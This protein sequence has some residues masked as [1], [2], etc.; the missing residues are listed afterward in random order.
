M[1]PPKDIARSY[2]KRGLTADVGFRSEPKFCGDGSAYFDNDN[3]TATLST[4]PGSSFS[5]GLWMNVS[6]FVPSNQAVLIEI[7]AAGSAG[8]QVTI[9]LTSTGQVQIFNGSGFIGTTAANTVSL[10]TWHFI[11]VAVDGSSGGLKIYVDGV[12]VTGTHTATFN[13]TDKGMTV[14]A[15][16]PSSSF[17]TEGN[18]AN[19]FYCTEIL[20]QDQVRQIMRFSSSSQFATITGMESFYPLSADFND[21][22][23]SANLTNSGATLQVT[24]KPQLPRGLDLV[25]GAAQARCFTGRAVEFDGSAD[26]LATETSAALGNTFTITAWIKRNNSAT[27]DYIVNVGNPH[28]AG[29]AI[30]ISIT[31]ANPGYLYFF[32]NSTS[33]NTTNKVEYNTWYHVAL[34]VSSGA[35][36]VKLYANGVDGTPSNSVDVNITDTTFEIGRYL[37]N[38]HFHN[39]WISDVRVY[40]QTLTAA[41]VKELYQHPEQLLPNGSSASNLIHRWALSDYND[42]GGTG[43]RHFQDSAGSNPMEDKASAQM[44]FAQPVPCPQLGLQQSASRI[45]WDDNTAEKLS[46]T[47]PAFDSDFTIAF[48]WFRNN[49]ADADV[50]F[51]VNTPGLYQLYYD[52]TQIVY[53][54][55]TAG[56]VYTGVSCAV[57]E[58]SHVAITSAGIFKNGVKHTPAF[59]LDWLGTEYRIF[60]RHSAAL[61][62]DGICSNMGFWSDDLSTAAI[63]EL[64]NQ[65]P[66]YDPRNDTGNYASSSTLTNLWFMDDLATIKD[67]KGSNDLTVIGDPILASFPENAS[68]S[69]LVGDFSMKRKGVSVLNCFGDPGDERVRTEIPSGAGLQPSLT[70]GH[71]VSCWYRNQKQNTTSANNG[72]MVLGGDD[73]GNNRFILEAFNGNTLRGIYGA[74]TATGTATISDNEWHHYAMVLDVTTASPT[75]RLYLDGV[76]AGTKSGSLSTTFPEGKVVIGGLNTTTSRGQFDYGLKGPIACARIYAFQL[77]ENEIKQIYH[78]DERLIKG[79]N[80]E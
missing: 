6:D 41:Q 12:D 21:A 59:T 74:Q 5:Y 58:W 75:V 13:V 44:E 4:T 30:S 56:V 15:Y 54:S 43:G 64:Y 7:G 71:T 40:N 67:R 25:R 29:N 14:G 35:G 69:T 68:G 45:Y 3:A 37:G 73:S 79:L 52:L 55:S 31:N 34:T 48:W 46:A 47:I 51:E 19:V 26:Y 61:S 38:S 23:G 32:D 77:S 50:W 2:P 49:S 72:T 27:L 76:A 1:A 20:T 65:G 70:N 10:N 80:N 11:A 18:L 42:T 33:V 39:G 62:C 60:G 63:L 22:I 36:G 28:G 8:S 24:T 66:D 53:Y 78:A 9:T 17:Y 57:G 16:A